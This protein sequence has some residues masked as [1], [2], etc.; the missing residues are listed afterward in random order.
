MLKDDEKMCEGVPTYGATPGYVETMPMDGD[1]MGMGMDMD[2]VHISNI[3]SCVGFGRMRKGQEW[4]VTA[5][6]D[7][8]MHPGMQEMDG[9]L[10][11]VMGISILYI[12]DEK[13][14]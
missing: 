12:L 10:S 6:Y 9:S 14:A 11:P 2:M 4:G 13:K 3:S 1:G 7:F 5:R 8:D